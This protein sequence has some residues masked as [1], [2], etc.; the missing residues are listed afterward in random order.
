[1]IVSINQPCYLG[2]LGYFD[3][4][5]LSD[6][7][8]VLD[9]VKFEKGSFTNRTRIR[10]PDGRTCFLTIPVEKGKP[11]RDTRVM[12]DWLRKHTLT[13]SQAYGC[14]ELIA[15]LR[16]HRRLAP[17]LAETTNWLLEK[18]DL[19]VEQVSSTVLN[20]PGRKSELVL[21]LCKE[22]GATTYLSGPFGR[23]YLDEPSFEEAG[24]EVRYHDYKPVGPA[25][26][27]LDYL[28]SDRSEEAWPPPDSTSPAC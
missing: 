8:I 11:I 6:L 1:M 4:I 15:V 20:V 5:R 16:S 12:G 25:L 28:Y 9:H 21:N 14:Y 2:W 24:I 13:L 27:A 17:I 7:H 26:S 22:V 3:R 19:D 10:Q 18:L 23:D